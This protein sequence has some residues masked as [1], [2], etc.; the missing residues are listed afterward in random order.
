MIR[1][2]VG[3]DRSGGPSQQHVACVVK[4][5]DLHTQSGSIRVTEI[6]TR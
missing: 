5:I 1:S 6:N 2:H 4:P 3:S